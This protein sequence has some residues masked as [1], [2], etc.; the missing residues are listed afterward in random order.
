ERLASTRLSPSEA[1]DHALEGAG[2]SPIGQPMTLE[3]L[4]RRPEVDYSLLAA[5]DEATAQVPTEVGERALVRIKYQ[6]YIVRQKAMAER[7]TALESLLIPADID[8]GRLGGLSA[9]VKERL[10]RG[11]PRSLGQASRLS[12][13][14]PAA[15]SILLV[16]LRA[17]G[18]RRP[19]GARQLQ[20]PHL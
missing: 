7:L 4:L 12:G 10:E 8:Y 18:A 17:R 1:L 13:I 16:H 11:R 19:R 14:T 6:G 2:S 3:E 5:F 15:L 20:Q 9:E